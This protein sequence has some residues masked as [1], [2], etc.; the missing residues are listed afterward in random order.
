[1]CNFA[2]ADAQM[3]HRIPDFLSHFVAAALDLWRVAFSFVSFTP[4]LDPFR[5]D[6]PLWRL[7]RPIEV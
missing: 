4:W 5:P 7:P 2:A 3:P 1:M 6:A